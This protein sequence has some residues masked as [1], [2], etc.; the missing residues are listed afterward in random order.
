MDNSFDSPAEILFEQAPEQKF[1]W[2]NVALFALTC[3]STLVMGTLFM[4]AYTN[5]FTDL[6]LLLSQ[7]LRSPSVLLS[8]IPFSLAI[9]TILLGHEMGHYLT[10][11]YYG[12][13]AT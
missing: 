11:R 13:D 6:G 7:I 2:V 5:S 1:P 12:I 10:C 3:L 4:A 9:M 8:G